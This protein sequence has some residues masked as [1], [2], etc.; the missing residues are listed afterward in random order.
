M[1]E[2]A[3]LDHLAAHGNEE[4]LVELYP[5]SRRWPQS[6]PVSGAEAMERDLSSWGADAQPV[7][8]AWVQGTE[9][10]A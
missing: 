10:Q 5:A 3:A 1:I 4:Q 8:V 2:A 9:D 6:S 7:W